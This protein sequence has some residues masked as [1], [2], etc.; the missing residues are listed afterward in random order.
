MAYHSTIGER[1]L[2]SLVSLKEDEIIWL[3]RTSPTTRILERI[4]DIL[5]TDI[6]SICLLIEGN[7]FNWIILSR[8][9]CFW[10][11]LVTD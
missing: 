5:I 8:E 11:W 7:I 10:V 3:V 6:N 1:V 2:Y 4:L 9:K